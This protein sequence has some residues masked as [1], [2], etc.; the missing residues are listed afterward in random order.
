[1]REPSVLVVDDDAEILSVIEGMFG[2]V[3]IKV[4]CAISANEALKWLQLKHYTTM[5]TDLD[6]PGMDGLELAHKARQISPTL[7]VVLFTGNT[8]RE[9]SQSALTPETS[10]ISEIHAKPGGLRQML[11]SI[12][13]RDYGRT[14]EMKE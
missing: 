13:W 8:T 5:I 6:M 1:M 9:L 11:R 10:D 12:L 3:Q 4:D 7:Y 14:F 2:S